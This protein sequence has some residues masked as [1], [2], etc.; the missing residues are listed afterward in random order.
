MAQLRQPVARVERL[1]NPSHVAIAA[2]GF[3]FTFVGLGFGGRVRS[4]HPTKE[5]LPGTAMSICELRDAAIVP[6]ICPTC[7]NV[8]AGV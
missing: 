3:A 6:V 1:Q 2:M 4:T 8:L 7:Q 5:P